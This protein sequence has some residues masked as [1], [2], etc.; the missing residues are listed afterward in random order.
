MR[1]KGCQDL[2]H[3]LFAQALAAQ[4]LC[5][6]RERLRAVHFCDRCHLF[7]VLTSYFSIDSDDRIIF[8]A[9]LLACAVL[10]FLAVSCLAGRLFWCYVMEHGS[11]VCESL[12]ELVLFVLPPHTRH[13]DATIAAACEH[14]VGARRF[15]RRGAP[16]V[17]QAH[18]RW[19]RAGDSY[20]NGLAI[21]TGRI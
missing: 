5:A 20:R 21:K 15:A 18:N 3:L 19:M 7:L 11:T 17:R 12:F 4:R 2:V 8:V 10:F 1:G 6:K 9:L 16:N 14:R 13:E